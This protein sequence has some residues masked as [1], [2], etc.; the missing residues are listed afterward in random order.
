MLSLIE[1]KNVFSYYT[2]HTVEDALE[3]IPFK[4]VIY[5]ESEWNFD[6]TYIHR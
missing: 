2:V 5:I 6:L 4:P 1:K 3:P